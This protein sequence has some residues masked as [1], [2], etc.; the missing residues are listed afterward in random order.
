MVAWKDP[1]DSELERGNEE[2]DG[3]PGGT[4]RE[5]FEGDACDESEDRKYICQ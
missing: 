3:E 1:D 4:E 2:R 5:Y